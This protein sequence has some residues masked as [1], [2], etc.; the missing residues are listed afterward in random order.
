[1]FHNSTTIHRDM[2]AQSFYTPSRIVNKLEKTKY[3]VGHVS[4]ILKV[5][6]LPITWPA[7]V[8]KAATIGTFK[9]THDVAEQGYYTGKEAV[10]GVKDAVINPAWTMAF[11]EGVKIKRILW[12]FPIATFKAPFKAMF[13]L[14]KTPFA[15]A[16]ATRESVTSV[17]KD[18][19]GLGVDI[20][21]LKPAIK[22]L[23]AIGSGR[24]AIKE[25][26][27]MPID[28]GK[29]MKDMGKNAISPYGEVIKPIVEPFYEPINTLGGAYL[30]QF[31]AAKKSTKH[32]VSGTK[33]IW[34]A[35]KTG[36][37]RH[38]SEKEKRQILFS[39]KAESVK[40]DEVR[41]KE[42]EEKQPMNQT[43]ADNHPNTP[44]PGEADM[45]SD[46]TISE[47]A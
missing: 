24:N 2:N 43:T 13:A 31:V 8:T 33:R 32:V 5:A 39:Q 27:S 37:A 20:V 9:K 7:V 28:L 14:A 21:T 3:V 23:E 42:S 46:N 29:R 12:D 36:R 4:K 26:L 22:L 1:M 40:E 44:A 34:N 25:V 10:L 17:L 30:Q 16:K 18:S 45:E 19:W 15:L 6:T 47:D 35:P 38:L 41:P 11:S